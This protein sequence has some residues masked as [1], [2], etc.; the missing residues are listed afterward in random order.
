M[1]LDVYDIKAQ[2][3]DKVE[4]KL[5]KI[6][7][8]DYELAVALRVY[9]TN[10]HQ[11]TRQAKTR[12]EIAFS[13]RKPWRQ[14]GTGRAR[15]GSK[16]SP[17]WVKGAVAHGPRPYTKRLHLNK[18]QKRRVFN[19]LLA[20]VLNDKKVIVLDTD[21]IAD[22]VKTR[23]AKDFVKQ[24][25]LLPFKTFYVADI[26]DEQSVM[27]FRNLRN[28]TIRRADLLSPRD[29]FKGYNMIITL[30]AFNVLKSRVLSND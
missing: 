7:L 13:N 18:Q 21:S 2:K 1:K 24:V 29:L 28:I 30:S 23:T 14:K 27:M 25:G 5:P 4:L 12:G 10:Q 8:T 9:E 19:Y 6:D 17:I 15:A 11:G 3:K 22:S 20:Q 26:T 16:S